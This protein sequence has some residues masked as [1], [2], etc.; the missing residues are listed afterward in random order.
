MG[1][2][3]PKAGLKVGKLIDWGFAVN[4]AASVF[5]STLI[6]LIALSF[7]YNVSLLLGML[8]YICA[9]LLLIKKN[10]WD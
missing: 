9:F 4:G 2:P 6:I 8:L 1:M 5:G 3:F 7:G 10:A